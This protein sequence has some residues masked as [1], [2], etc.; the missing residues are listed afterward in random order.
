MQ[1]TK[2]TIYFFL[3]FVLILSACNKTEFIAGKAFPMA[4]LQQLITEY[5]QPLDINNKYLLIN[6][7]ATWCSPC[8]KEMPALQQL[9]NELDKNKFLV[10]GISIDE[11]KNLMQ[12][13]LLQH[14]IYFNNLHDPKQVLATQQ[15]NIQGY[16]ETFIVSPDGIII[17]RITGEQNWNSEKKRAMMKSFYQTKTP[18]INK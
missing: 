8:R 18:T 16:P 1:N 17:K 6:F 14:K 4:T 12:E 13:F 9:S 3:L 5:N 2:P 15:L 7:W 10:L 11:D